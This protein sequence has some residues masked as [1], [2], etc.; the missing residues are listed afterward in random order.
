[1]LT[2]SDKI[3]KKQKTENLFRA[4]RELARKD[5]DGAV[6]FY[7]RCK[8]WKVSKKRKAKHPTIVK[9]EINY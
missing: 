6:L 7:N 1:M 5:L 8:Y 9:Q 3:R 2:V 4:E